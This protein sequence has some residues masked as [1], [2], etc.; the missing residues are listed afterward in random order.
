V[1]VQES[2]IFFFHSPTPMMIGKSI[3]TD[4]G[5]GDRALVCKARQGCWYPDFP[6][7]A[8]P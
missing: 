8:M 7:V 5:S 1:V 6:P 3:M 4:R 2:S